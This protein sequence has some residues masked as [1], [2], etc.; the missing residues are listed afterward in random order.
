MEKRRYIICRRPGPRDDTGIS[1]GGLGFAS[2]IP[3]LELERPAI[4]KLQQE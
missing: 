2:H 3:D 4:K 1:H